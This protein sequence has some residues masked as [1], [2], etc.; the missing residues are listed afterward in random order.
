ML[1]FCHL[2]DKDKDK[3]CAQSKARVILPNLFIKSN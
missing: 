1:Q 2:N 3:K